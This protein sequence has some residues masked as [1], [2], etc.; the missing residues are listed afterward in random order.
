MRFFYIEQ[1]FIICYKL[2]I[3]NVTNDLYYND[4]YYIEKF[5]G[6]VSVERSNK[7]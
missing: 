2:I 3:I 7:Y 4:L 6:G 1:K 5:N